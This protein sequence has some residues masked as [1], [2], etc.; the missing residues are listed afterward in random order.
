MSGRRTPR[1]GRPTVRPHAPHRS[2]RDRDLVRPRHPRGRAGAHA[3]GTG[4]GGAVI[5]RLLAWFA[6]P[7]TWSGSDGITAR[8]LEHLLYSGIVVAIA[9]TTFFTAKFNQA[10][11]NVPDPVGP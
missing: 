5:S 10:R 8:V 6:D 11:D 4:G 9:A 7:A 3:V 2:A 1:V